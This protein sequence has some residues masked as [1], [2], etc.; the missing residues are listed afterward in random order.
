M[1]NT[2]GRCRHHNHG[3]EVVGRHD[4]TH[5]SKTNRPSFT[6]TTVRQ[7]KEEKKGRVGLGSSSLRCS[8]GTSMTTSAS[9]EERGIDLGRAGRGTQAA[10]DERQLWLSDRQ[11]FG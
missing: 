4:V 6:S 5:K 7:P 11:H 9:S 10:Q 8:R 2:Q 3:I 1:R